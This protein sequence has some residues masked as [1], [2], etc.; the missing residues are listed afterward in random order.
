MDTTGSTNFV[1]FD[2]VVTQFLGKTP[3]QLLEPPCD[4]AVLPVDFQEFVNKNLLFKVEIIEGN[5]THHWQHVVVK[6]LTSD[7][8]V[9]GSFLSKYKDNADEELEFTDALID[10]TPPSPLVCFFSFVTL[11]FFSCIHCL[12]CYLHFFLGFF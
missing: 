7:E 12:I 4:P 9:I 1:L 6:R 11:G 5:V 3:Q 10:Y 2:R 8:A